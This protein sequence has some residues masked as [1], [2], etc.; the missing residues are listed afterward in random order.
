MAS[1]LSYL[2]YVH[3]AADPEPMPFA[4]VGAEAGPTP[5]HA[6]AAAAL[7]ATSISFGD[8]WQSGDPIAHVDG[9]LPPAVD[10]AARVLLRGLA[11]WLSHAAGPADTS[12]AV[13][14]AGLAN[15]SGVAHHYYDWRTGAGHDVN[16][17]ATPRRV[18]GW[19]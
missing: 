4:P 1:A 17:R 16:R 8:T 5:M 10:H 19:P 6:D 3:D 13:H 12:A 14:T 15:T 9:T 18:A 11:T 7:F 2:A